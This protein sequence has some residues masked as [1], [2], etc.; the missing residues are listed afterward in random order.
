MS[1]LFYGVGRLIKTCSGGFPNELQRVY[2]V[3]L[4]IKA[5]VVEAHE[6]PIGRRYS[7]LL[8]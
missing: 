2:L 8:L 6:G 1:T 4:V 7:L 3:N 5:I